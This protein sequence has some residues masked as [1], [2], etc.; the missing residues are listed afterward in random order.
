[1]NDQ[2]FETPP[3]SRPQR[4]AAARYAIVVL[5]L[6]FVT[7]LGWVTFAGVHPMLAIVFSAVMFLALYRWE[8]WVK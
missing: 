6:T 1:M 4:I 3:L 5:C 2:H 8:R 7:L